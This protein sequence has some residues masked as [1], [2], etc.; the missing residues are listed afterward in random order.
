APAEA[1]VETPAPSQPEA[2]ASAPA[3]ASKSGY[4]RALLRPAQLK[5]KAPET[6]QVKFTT[7]RGDFVVAVTRA[8]APLGADRFYNLVK[9][10]FYDGVSCFRAIDGF[11]VQFGIT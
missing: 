4:D 3:A 9:I 1:K 5:E 6:F 8:W 2:V 11:M 10:G 7:T